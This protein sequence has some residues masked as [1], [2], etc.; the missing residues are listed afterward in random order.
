MKRAIQRRLR[1]INMV[2]ADTDK[3]IF[4]GAIGTTREHIFSEWT[5]SF[6]LPRVNRKAR[7]HI[8]VSYEDRTDVV[9]DLKMPG[10]IQDWQIKCVCARC[11]NEWMNDIEKLAR[12]IIEPLC[13]GDRVRL[14][15]ADQK[16]IAIWAIIKIMVVHHRYVHH[17]QR[18]QMMEKQEPPRRWGVWVATHERG[19]WRTQFLSRPMGLDPPGSIRRSGRRGG[20]PTS[21]ATTQIIKKL[22]IH[23]VKLPMDD[24]AAGWRWTDPATLPLSVLRVWPLS[25]QSFLW[26][27]KAL[28]DLEAEAVA[29]AVYRAYLRH[30]ARQGFRVRT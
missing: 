16:I 5:H 15:E 8:A 21:H 22:L 14:S 3:C 11:N 23:V 26:P 19:N 2:F 25:G 29:D 13:R 1:L 6:F 20:V 18:K 12:P 24:F 7:M 28:T 30:A 9:D 10:P 17:K 4:C 27:Q